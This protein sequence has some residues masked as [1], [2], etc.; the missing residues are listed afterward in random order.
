MSYRLDL[1]EYIFLALS[2]VGILISFIMGKDVSPVAVFLCAS[3][4]LNL[5][6]RYQIEQSLHHRLNHKA[7]RMQQQVTEEL[8]SIRHHLDRLS[9]TSS[10][11]PS[12]LRTQYRLS[13]LKD[14]EE[15]YQEIVEVQQHCEKMQES[16]GWVMESLQHTATADRVAQLEDSLD[17]LYQHLGIEAELPPE[18]PP[19]PNFP[20]IE[21]P[22]DKTT[23]VRAVSG[24]KL[25]LILPRFDT[26]PEPEAE[27]E[28]EPADSPE[29]P[30]DPPF[31]PTQTWERTAILSDHS[32][33]TNDLALSPDGT[34]LISA[35]F[36]RTVQ[37][38]ELPAGNSAAIL[39][40]HRAPVW[41][42]AL[43]PDNLLVSGGLD[44]TVLLWD[45]EKEKP[46]ATLTEEQA[47][48]VRSLALST[49]G[50]LLATGWFDRHIRIWRLKPGK[51]KRA[52][53]TGAIA[54][55]AHA[56]K[57]EALAFAPDGTVLASGGA[58]GMVKLWRLDPKERR[59]VVGGERGDRPPPMVL[60]SSTQPITGLGWS[61]DGQLLAASSYDGKVRL[62]QWPGGDRVGELT[63]NGKAITAMAWAGNDMLA[64]GSGDGTLYIWDP[65]QRTRLATLS[66]SGGAVMAI[67]LTATGDRLLAGCTDGTIEIWE[68]QGDNG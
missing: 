56:G 25:D 20:T 55:E 50:L 18:P 3:I 43:G 51:R 26:E 30:P 64:G 31:V 54:F 12:S 63:G 11:L 2:V 57:V 23:P 58:E 15:L 29:P 13:H 38:W 36:D 37:V 66:V 14:L 53:P 6:R 32:D 24:E 52:I 16:I 46:I 21:L 67:A 17:R 33:W 34:Q 22:F 44:K 8:N 39:S 47:G 10:S 35:S 48:S 45:L 7:T 4:A 59:V 28:P 1:A 42:I 65:Q 61:A 68:R 49:D 40:D 9:L 60:D 62:W 27:P 5:I 41:A 19:S